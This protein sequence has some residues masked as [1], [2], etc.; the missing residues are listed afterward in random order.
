M[1]PSAMNI[2]I[3]S[4]RPDFIQIKASRFALWRSGLY[5]S[6]I[7]RLTFWPGMMVIKY[8]RRDVLIIWGVDVTFR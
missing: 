3:V 1:S 5:L 6:Y 4:F 7:A 2:R 8:E